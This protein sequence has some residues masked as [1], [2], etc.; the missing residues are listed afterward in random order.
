MSS[1]AQR[2]QTP[3]ADR[4]SKAVSPRAPVA[5]PAMAP[6]ARVRWSPIGAPGFAVGAAA[7]LFV[8]L[9][10]FLLFAVLLVLMS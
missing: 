10:A 7:L 1:T 8:V 5:S 3:P 6:P 4:P 2:A 9:V